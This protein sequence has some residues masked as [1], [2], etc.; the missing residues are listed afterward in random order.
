MSRFTVQGN[1]FVIHHGSADDLPMVTKT[2]DIVDGKITFDDNLT[3]IW[4]LSCLGVLATINGSTVKVADIQ[5]SRK[6]TKVT[7][8]RKP[9]PIE[10]RFGNGATHYRDFELYECVNKVGKIKEWF[11]D[12]SDGLRYH[13]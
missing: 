6:I 4:E 7:Y 1:L 10:I 13:L 8:H 5:N 12:Q 9:T 2:Y 3:A 11:V